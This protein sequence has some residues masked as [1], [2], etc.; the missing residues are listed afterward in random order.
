MTDDYAPRPEDIKDAYRRFE[1]LSD[2][3][4]PESEASDQRVS[5]YWDGRAAGFGEVRCKELQS[6]RRGLWLSE[7]RPLLPS[8][9]GPLRILDIGTGTG[10]FAILMAQ[11]GHEAVGVDLSPQMIAQAR[12]IARSCG[13]KPEF[14][15]M[16]A[17]ELDFPDESFDVVL[18]RNLTWT[19]PDVRAAYKEWIRVLRHGGVFV[20]FDADYGY[21]S[22]TDLTRRLRQE[23]GKNAHEGI[24]EEVLDECDT[25]KRD[26]SISWV[27]RPVWDE[28]VLRELGC[29]CVESDT[30]L[31]SRI[32]REQDDSWNPV[33]MFRLSCRRP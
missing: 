2:G 27:P 28:S 22:F 7:I 8:S 21:V 6:A 32:Y 11:L 10:F 12:K 4:S 14:R 26:L 17:L 29:V 31:S 5:R 9:K 33:A 18:T 25:I 20:N 15:L 30:G 1:I 24:G 23:G 19:L 13:V 16:N 3:V